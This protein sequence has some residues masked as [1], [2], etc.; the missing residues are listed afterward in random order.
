MINP[1][2]SK[3]TKD[4]PDITILALAWSFYWRLFVVGM[5]VAFVIGVISEL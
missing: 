1:K 4:N 2:F 3:F 5:G